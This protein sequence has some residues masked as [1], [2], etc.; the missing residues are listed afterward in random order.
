VVVKG[1][2]SGV[3]TSVTATLGKRKL[4]V[5]GTGVWKVIVPLKR[6]RNVLL[7]VAHGAG[8]DSQP[9]RVVVI[10]RSSGG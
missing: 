8:G 6:G 2:A 7:V 10:R 4:A 9:V 5:K 1:A 3:V